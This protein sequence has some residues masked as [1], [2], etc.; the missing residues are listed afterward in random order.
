MSVGAFAGREDIMRLYNPGSG[1]L[2]H[3][4]TFNNNV[5]S[6]SSGVAGCS[7]LSQEVLDK[8]NRKGQ[9]MKHK[10]DKVLQ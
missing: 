2:D 3:P 4:G 8:P 7:V 9:L 5:L 10:I 1:Q 6:M